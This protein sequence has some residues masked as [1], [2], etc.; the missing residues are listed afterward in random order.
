MSFFHVIFTFILQPLFFLSELKNYKKC[1]YL[2]DAKCL[3]NVLFKKK[4]N[5]YSFYTNNII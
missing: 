2:K 4:K 5:I 1:K 3:L